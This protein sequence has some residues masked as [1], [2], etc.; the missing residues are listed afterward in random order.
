MLTAPKPFAATVTRTSRPG[1]ISVCTTDADPVH[2][3]S[4]LEEHDGDTAVLADRHALRGGDRIV[5]Y[6]PFERATPER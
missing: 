1:T 6:Q 3:L 2:V 5:L 4:D